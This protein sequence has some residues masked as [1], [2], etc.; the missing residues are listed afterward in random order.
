MFISDDI[1]NILNH[2]TVQTVIATVFR[3]LDSNGENVYL[4]FDLRPCKFSAIAKE[5]NI[6]GVHTAEKLLNS[7][8]MPLMARMAP[9]T[10]PQ[11]PAGLKS[12]SHFTSELR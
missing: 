11:L 2:E 10:S 9:S 6:S 8:R 7:K 3:C 12:S 5:D 1:H 4:P